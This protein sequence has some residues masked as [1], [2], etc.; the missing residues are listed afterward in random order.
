M[1][2]SSLYHLN[3][4]SIDINVV[5]VSGCR[6]GVERSTSARII[7]GTEVNPVSCKILSSSAPALLC[8]KL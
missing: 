2:L 3:Y 6:C 4:E 1:F 8:S 7:G 5:L